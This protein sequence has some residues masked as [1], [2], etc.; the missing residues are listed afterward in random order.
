MSSKLKRLDQLYQSSGRKNVSGQILTIPFKKI[1]YLESGL[2]KV[3]GGIKNWGRWSE[4]VTV[5]LP[6]NYL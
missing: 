3:F 2:A 4:I 5:I 1:S 6:Q